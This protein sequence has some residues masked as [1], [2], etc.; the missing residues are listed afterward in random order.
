MAYSITD[1]GVNFTRGKGAA[2]VSLVISFKELEDWARRQKIDTEKLMQRSF[3]RSCAGLKKKFREVV[4][5]AGGVCG[6]PKFKDFEEF[7]K[8]LRSRNGRTAPMGGLL[9]DPSAIFG[10]RSGGWYYV[11]W[12]DYLKNPAEKFQEGAGGE[13]S[14]KYFT[15]PE[16]RQSWHRKGLREIPRQYAH[17]PRRV[18][19][20]PFGG[21]VKEHLEEWARGV[22][23][24]DLA[25]QMTKGAK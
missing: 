7:T 21:F 18:L 23:Y 24:K 1:V 13:A 10:G 5:N 16:W 20:E 25:K 6:V 17:N 4:V 19:P 22:F 12:K 2:K 11:G 14:E 9:A 8:E 3:L 15:D